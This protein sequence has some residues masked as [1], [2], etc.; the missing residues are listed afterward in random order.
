MAASREEQFRT[1]QQLVALFKAQLEW[2]RRA[3]PDGVGRS[4]DAVNLARYDE[5]LAQGPTGRWPAGFL[6]GLK[7]GIRDCQVMLE[8]AY[9]ASER[10]ALRHAL[11]VAAGKAADLL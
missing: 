1:K 10:S 8:M 6:S 3:D 7:E 11:R 9:P 4:L 2:L 5:L